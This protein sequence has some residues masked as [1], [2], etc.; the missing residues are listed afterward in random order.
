MMTKPAFSFPQE[1][2]TV[3]WI[4]A[5]NIAQL[6]VFSCDGNNVTERYW[7]GSSWLTG[8]LNAPGSNVSASVYVLNGQANL[9]VYCTTE[10]VTT[11]Y[12][13]DGGSAWYK[14]SYTPS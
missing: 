12:C 7:G 13:Q 2:A 9:R 5:N 6:H 11:E 8:S 14:G 10:G 1:T 3:S 4:D